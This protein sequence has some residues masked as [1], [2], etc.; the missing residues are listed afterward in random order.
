MYDGLGDILHQHKVVVKD[1]QSPKCW[2]KVGFKCYFDKKLTY[3]FAFSTQNIKSYFSL[4]SMPLNDNE[5]KNKPNLFT[6]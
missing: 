4:H 6:I 3:V 5:L 2:G 1:E